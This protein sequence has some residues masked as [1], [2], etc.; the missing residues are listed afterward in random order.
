MIEE[1]LSREGEGE[2]GDGVVPISRMA[3][4]SIFGEMAVLTGRRDVL[5][6]D[7]M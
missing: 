2:A 4:G 6:H 7:C 3:A 1:L 5:L